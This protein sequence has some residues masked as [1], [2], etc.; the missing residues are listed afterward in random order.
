[1]VAG[2][3]LDVADGLAA[4]HTGTKSPL[5][6]AIDAT[7][8]KLGALAVLIVVGVIGMV[9]WAVVLLIAL[10]NMVNSLLAYYA[11]RRRT[12]LQPVRAG[13]LSTALEWLSLSAFMFATAYS[14]AWLGLAYGAL[15]PALVLGLVA[16]YL[17][18]RTLFAAE[19]AG[20][21]TSSSERRI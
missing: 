19:I 18:W 15:V 12:P 2:R 10:P 13:K 9:P 1:V 17:Y 4:E 3:I 11:W 5:G 6:G 21:S 14:H 8:D 20:V 7:F 16:T